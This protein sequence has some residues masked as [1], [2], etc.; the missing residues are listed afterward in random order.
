MNEENSPPQ[1]R[2]GARRR[3]QGKTEPVNFFPVLFKRHD[4]SF[5]PVNSSASIG[6]HPA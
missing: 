6:E 2:E 1:A 5:E 3:D 4:L